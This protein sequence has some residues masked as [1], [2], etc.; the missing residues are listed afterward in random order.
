[1]NKTKI[2]K[3][4]KNKIKKEQNTEREK[5]SQLIFFLQFLKI[6]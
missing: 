6:D 4:E 3:R 5:I 2:I 1:M